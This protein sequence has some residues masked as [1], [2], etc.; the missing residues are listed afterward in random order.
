MSNAVVI[1]EVEASRTQLQRRR[2][3]HTATSPDGAASL[4]KGVAGCDAEEDEEIARRG[5][6]GTHSLS[7]N[8]LGGAPTPTRPAVAH[9]PCAQKRSCHVKIKPPTAPRRNEASRAP[10]DHPLCAGGAPPTAVGAPQW[11]ATAG[12]CNTGSH[13]GHAYSCEATPAPIAE[14]REFQADTS[15]KLR[16]IPRRKQLRGAQHEI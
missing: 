7:P 10:V 9:S 2:G 11:Q 15:Q 4:L 16:V 13:A 6:T 3:C 12:Q 8:T 5:A 1:P 14:H